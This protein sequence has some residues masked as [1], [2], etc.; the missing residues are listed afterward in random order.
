MEVDRG[1]QFVAQIEAAQAERDAAVEKARETA[2][3]LEEAHT[4]VRQL[5]DSL[6]S[7]QRELLRRGRAEFWVRRS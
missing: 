7:S 3:T 1:S 2:A 4:R 6:A 5:Q